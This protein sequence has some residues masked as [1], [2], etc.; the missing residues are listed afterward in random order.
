MTDDFVSRNVYKQY[1]L[2]EYMLMMLSGPWAV[3]RTPLPTP[4]EDAE[5]IR[6]NMVSHFRVACAAI[7]PEMLAEFDLEQ[8]KPNPLPLP[9]PDLMRK[10]DD[11]YP[12]SAK[13]L[14]SLAKADQ[15][16]KQRQVTIALYKETAK[17]FGAG[18]ILLL[19]VAGVAI[20]VTAGAAGIAWY[21]IPP[22]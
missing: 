9:S 19:F 10:Y 17:I 2:W 14:F 12:G 3:P 18:I 8:T 13:R 7:S 11:L 22:A 5:N 16:K 1:S 15:R 21:I 20:T 6:L 4:I